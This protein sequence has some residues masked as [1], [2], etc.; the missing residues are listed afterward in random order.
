MS[1]TWRLVTTVLSDGRDS[2]RRETRT[3]AAESAGAGDV[4][5]ASGT[6]G[7]GPAR[8]GA[9]L[10]NEG[11]SGWAIAV[12]SGFGGVRDSDGGSSDWT[13]VNGS[14]AWSDFTNEVTSS[15]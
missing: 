8:S 13:R 9:N 2:A 14:P 11:T 4:R 3:G 10:A 15:V 7:S 6:A 5:R 1:S 12:S